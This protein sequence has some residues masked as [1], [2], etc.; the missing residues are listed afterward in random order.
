MNGTNVFVCGT[1]MRGECA[2][3]FLAD[4]KFVGEYCLR[5]YAIYN[6]GWY[7]GICP[8]QGSI[9]YGEVYAVDD[10]ML[11]ET[12]RYEGEGSLYRRTPVTV[13]NDRERIDAAT[14]VYAQEIHKIEIADGRWNH[15]ENR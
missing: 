2:H 13:E 4:A 5:D 15:G 14:Y 11:R 1:L 7:P 3:S 8:K 6:L 12:D 10:R 9:V